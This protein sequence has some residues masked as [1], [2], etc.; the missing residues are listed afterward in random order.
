MPIRLA[1]ALCLVLLAAACS[2][3]GIAELGVPATARI[4]YGTGFF[5]G[6]DG[7]VVTAAHVVASCRQI[8]VWSAVV[9]D[10]W[11]T[12]L[13]A[14]RGDDVALLHVPVVAP[15][16]LTGAAEPV[17]EGKLQAFGY[18]GGSNALVAEETRPLL[19]NA[20]ARPGTPSD[21]R[22]ILWLQDP[23]IRHGW[24]GGPVL[25][26]EGR[27][28]GMVVAVVPDPAAATRLLGAPLPGVAIAAGLTALRIA[29]DGGAPAAPA[30]IRRAVLHV[31][32]VR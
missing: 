19:V 16:V 20:R 26:A 4:G 22:D 5:V 11:A 15:A 6:A 30:D 21:P 9:P 32:C 10:L 7:L 18:S 14:S 12:L 1:L 24:S 2:P 31:R 3:P 23:V 27:V 29:P 8:D 17:M 13:R 25:D 28:A